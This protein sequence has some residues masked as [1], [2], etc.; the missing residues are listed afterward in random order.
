MDEVNYEEKQDVS[1]TISANKERAKILE[2]LL[3]KK[4]SEFTDS[5][6]LYSLRRVLPAELANIYVKNFTKAEEEDK[7]LINDQIKP[8]LGKYF[9]NKS[10]AKINETKGGYRITDYLTYNW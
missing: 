9:E 8:E 2:R 10:D 5:S 7:K 3:K 1:R 4:L 6:V